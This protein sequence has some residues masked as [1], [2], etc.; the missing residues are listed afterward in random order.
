VA[1]RAG[2]RVEL[3]R[4]AF[5]FD[6]VPRLRGPNYVA[7]RATGTVCED[8]RPLAV[9]HPEKRAYA[10]GGQVMTEAAMERGLTRDLYVALGEPLGGEA[11]A[12]R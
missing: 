4:H 10:S 7:D 6:G 8:D 1:V 5:R 3:D 9:L 11:W 12:L 2:E